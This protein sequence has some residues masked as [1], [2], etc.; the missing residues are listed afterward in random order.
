MKFMKTSSNLKFY[1][2]IEMIMIIV[3]TET[4]ADFIFYAFM[5]SQVNHR[6]IPE[7]R[8]CQFSD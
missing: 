8:L 2:M 4:E 1:S 3:I 5:V 6:I 7:D